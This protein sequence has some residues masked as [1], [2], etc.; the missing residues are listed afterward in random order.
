MMCYKDQTF[1]PGPCANEYCFRHKSH[2][3]EAQKE[4]G[5]LDKN[6]YVPVCWFIER[7]MDCK[8]YID[9]DEAGY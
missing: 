9:P 2:V 7:P 4:G 8:E 1:C 6:P 5:W 3:E